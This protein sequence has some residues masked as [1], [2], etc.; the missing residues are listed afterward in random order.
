MGTIMDQFF[1]EKS[2]NKMAKKEMNMISG[3]VNDYDNVSN[4]P[5]KINK[6]IH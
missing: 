4:D 3:T 6:R 1:A 2:K 5:K